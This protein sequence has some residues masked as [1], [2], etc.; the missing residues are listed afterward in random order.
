ML[1]SLGEEAFFEL[2]QLMRADT[3]AQSEKAR[4]RLAVLDRIEARAHALLQKGVALSVKDLAVTGRDLAGLGI[5][6]SPQMGKLLAAALD[7][8]TEG[9]VPNERDA[10]LQ[11]IENEKSNVE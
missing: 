6:P 3:V 2:L 10:L 8:V 9:T 5:P 4:P 7:A 11:F 1:S